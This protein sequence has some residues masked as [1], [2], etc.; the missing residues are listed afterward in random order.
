MPLNFGEFAVGAATVS[1][2]CDSPT[3]APHLNGGATIESASYAIV[4]LAPVVNA[5]ENKLPGGG[6][7][8]PN[9]PGAVIRELVRWGST[10][11]ISVTPG[12]WNMTIRLYDEAPEAPL[13]VEGLARSRRVNHQH[14]RTGLFVVEPGATATVSDFLTQRTIGTAGSGS[15]RVTIVNVLSGETA[16]TALLRGS[17]VTDEGHYIRLTGIDGTD[18]VE[19]TT[20]V[21]ILNDV[22]S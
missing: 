4:E 17:G 22:P 3:L 15:S 14:I 11:S 13:N 6:V 2:V 8:Q 10:A 21:T 5:A 18:Y 1:V 7:H 20:F 19:D 16:T 12:T 9:Y